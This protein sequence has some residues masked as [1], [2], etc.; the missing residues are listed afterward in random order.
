MI[1]ERLIAVSY[2]DYALKHVKKNIDRII[3][4][5]GRYDVGSYLKIIDID[6]IYGDSLKINVM[7]FDCNICPYFHEYGEVTKFGMFR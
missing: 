1:P 5:A 7:H 4:Y 3:K 2:F 6:D